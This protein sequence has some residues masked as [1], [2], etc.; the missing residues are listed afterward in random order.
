MVGLQLMFGWLQSA[1]PA[2]I[3]ELMPIVPLLRLLL[4][5]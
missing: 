5:L 4:K 2:P 3:L 1:L